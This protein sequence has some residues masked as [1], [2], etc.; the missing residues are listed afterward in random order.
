MKITI[1]REIFH[2][3]MRGIAGKTFGPD[4]MCEADRQRMFL[5]AE[6]LAHATAIKQGGTVEVD[7]T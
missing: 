6:R 3:M 1:D 2:Q 4:F 7:V 5:L